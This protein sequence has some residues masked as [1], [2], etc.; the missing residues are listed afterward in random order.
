N[1]RQMTPLENVWNQLTGSRVT[2][3]TTETTNMILQQTFS[4]LMSESQPIQ[5]TAVKIMSIFHPLHTNALTTEQFSTLR[6]MMTEQLLP[7]L[8]EATKTV[9]LSLLQQN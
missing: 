7:L 2:N 9:M 4:Q 6:N 1:S 8:P 5:A 3:Q